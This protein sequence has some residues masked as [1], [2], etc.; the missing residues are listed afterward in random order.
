MRWAG[1]LIILLLLD[2]KM[3]TAHTASVRMTDALVLSL[4]AFCGGRWNLRSRRQWII[5]LL[6]SRISAISIMDLLCCG[7]LKT[8]LLSVI[9]IRSESSSDQTI[10]LLVGRQ[11]PSFG[12]QQVARLQNRTRASLKMCRIRLT[13]TMAWLW[14]G[15]LRMELCQDIR[16]ARVVIG[17]HQ[18]I[19]AQ[20][21]RSWHSCIDMLKN[22]WNER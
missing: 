10:R 9:R 18:T 7:H 13:I 22:I 12:E 15:H 16:M 1:D 14:S 19:H 4:S 17:L 2:S 11:L 21:V 3:R 5:R 20:E 6:I 8:K